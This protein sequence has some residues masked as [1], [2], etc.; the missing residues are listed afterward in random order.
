M[1]TQVYVNVCTVYVNVLELRLICDKLYEKANCGLW[2][3]VINIWASTGPLERFTLTC[4][5]QCKR[6]KA[7]ITHEELQR[8]L[9]LDESAEIICHRLAVKEVVY[10]NQEV[11]EIHISK[12]Y[13]KI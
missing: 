7:M 11:P 13:V 4:Q 12:I 8:F 1:F 2:P 10:T 5:I 9:P 3:T 6:N